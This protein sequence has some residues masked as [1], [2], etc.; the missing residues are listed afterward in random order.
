MYPQRGT[1]P[2][3][4]ER[5]RECASIGVRPGTLA[6]CQRHLAVLIEREVHACAAAHQGRHRHGIG[7]AGLC[8]LVPEPAHRQAVQGDGDV[9]PLLS[10]GDGDARFASRRCHGAGPAYREVRR[11]A[12]IPIIALRHSIPLRLGAV[13]TEVG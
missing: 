11:Y 9:R 4:R 10:V 8:I 7:H 12:I 1:L 5:L 3:R 2:C 13:E 6:A